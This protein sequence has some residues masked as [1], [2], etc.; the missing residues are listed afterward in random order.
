MNALEELVEI[1]AFKKLRIEY[2]HYF[3]GQVDGRRLIHRT[4]IDFLWPKP[5]VHGPRDL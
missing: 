3:D 2:S 4:R 1:E 5:A